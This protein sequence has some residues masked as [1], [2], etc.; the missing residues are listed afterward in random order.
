MSDQE[1]A[2]TLA[3]ET[4]ETPI[5][6][7]VG[8]DGIIDL[9]APE[10]VKEEPKGETDKK[11]GEADEA[12]DKDAGEEGKAE[13]RKKLS[14]AQ[15]AKLRE[16]RLLQ[17][18]SELQRKL[19]EATRKAPAADA[20]DAEKAPREEDFNGD[21]FAYQTAKQAF[22]SRQA[23][24][25]E[26]RK[27][28]ETR[29]ASERET[30][31]AEI[32]R[33]RREAHLERV[34]GAREVIADFDQVMKAMDGVQVRQDVIEEIM[35]S[36]QSALI[37]YHLAK[38]PNELDALNAMNSREL[39]RAMGRLEAT[40]KMPEAK[41]QTSAPAPLSRPKGG[42]APPS[43]EAELA[44]YLNKTYGDRRR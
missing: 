18:N 7:P 20:S 43:Q 2:A 44:A 38:N 14:G 13:E 1:T 27:D 41:K 37:S 10:E 39:A 17:E 16:Q 19:E 22:E 36:D 11:D 29:E 33:E 5:V 4:T 12:S 3:V 23:I 32:A 30:K 42:A 25:D 6:T 24:R 8:E 34:E 31:Q 28:R 9:D 40:L 26:L 35:S 15:R 21:W